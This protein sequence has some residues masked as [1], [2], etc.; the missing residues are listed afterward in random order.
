MVI[1][2]LFPVN[3]AEFHCLK[4][5]KEHFGS[6]KSEVKYTINYTHTTIV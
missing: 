6:E 4:S 3:V 2:H 5:C 1:V